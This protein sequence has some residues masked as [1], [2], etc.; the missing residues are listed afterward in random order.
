VLPHGIQLGRI[1]L[2][3]A[4]EVV[5]IVCAGRIPLDLYRGRTLYPPRVQAA[6][7]AA[8][9]AT[10]CDVLDDLTLAAD[11][12]ERVAFTAPSGEVAIR[13]E[14]RE[15]P[16]APASCGA[17]PEATVVWATSLESST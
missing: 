1:P 16:S 5:D 6:E 11:A 14:R 3:R 10:G 15:G 17:E 13:V 12:G 4:A 7:V 9:A 2:D 8:R